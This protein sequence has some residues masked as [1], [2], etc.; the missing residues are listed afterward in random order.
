MGKIFGQNLFDD[1]FESYNG[2]P[3]GI[4]AEAKKKIS[5]IIR[6]EIEQEKFEDTAWLDALSA[7]DGNKTTAKGKYIKLRFDQLFAI[8]KNEM[9]LRI[10]E[11]KAKEEENQRLLD[12]EK[13]KIEQ[14]KA[15]IMARQM[16]QK[17]SKLWLTDAQRIKLSP[18]DKQK[19][20]EARNILLYSATP[21]HAGG[22]SDGE[23]LMGMDDLKKLKAKVK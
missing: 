3:G 2:L 10:N 9:N 8:F 7:A 11:I 22:P 23:L 18:A 1:F 20:V 17:Y 6:D 14:G 15:Q 21:T 13:M 4:T 16:E 12:Q 5:K 19:Y